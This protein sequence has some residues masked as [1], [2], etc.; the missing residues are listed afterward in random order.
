M[1]YTNEYIHITSHYKIS[2]RPVA[3][4]FYLVGK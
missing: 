2:Q 4:A 3:E 1:L